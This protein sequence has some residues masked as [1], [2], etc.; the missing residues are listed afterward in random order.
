ME[1]KTIGITFYQ[2]F[3][4]VTDAYLE[5]Q[6]NDELSKLKDEYTHCRGC[7]LH[8]TR[9]HGIVFGTGPLKSRLMV[10]GL[11]P[12]KY[13]GE[14]GVPFSDKLG[15][16]LRGMLEYVN[17]GISISNNVYLTNLVLCPGSPTE[18]QFSACYERL[19]AEFVL[20]DPK[21]VLFLGED[22]ANRFVVGP[23]RGKKLVFK[24]G[25][26]YYTGVQTHTLKDLLYRNSEVRQDVKSDLDIVVRLI[27][28]AENTST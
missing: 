14:I 16:K 19:H 27:R 24:L 5:E 13:D 25:E 21:V 11:A 3:K 4:T 20:V 8:K 15:D 12:S 17:D 26:K 23:K 2:Q 28:D 18:E 9:T 10:V 1:I 6:T 22:V 7:S